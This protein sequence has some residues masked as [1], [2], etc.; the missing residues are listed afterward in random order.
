MGVGGYCRGESG[1]AGAG[2]VG[3]PWAA[4]EGRGVEAV[5]ASR[6]PWGLTVD[7]KQRALMV[8]AEGCWAQAGRQGVCKR[9]LLCP[10]VGPDGHRT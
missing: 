7:G 3:V 9:H 6:V 2:I 10:Q 5:E 8:D 1:L 4:G